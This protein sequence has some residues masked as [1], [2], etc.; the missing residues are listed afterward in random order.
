[1]NER[2]TG[3][4]VIS[5]RNSS[6]LG[7]VLEGLRAVQEPYGDSYLMIPMIPYGDKYCYGRSPL[8]KEPP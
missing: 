1:M 7:G 8:I 3:E 4:N 5:E 2:G 6:T